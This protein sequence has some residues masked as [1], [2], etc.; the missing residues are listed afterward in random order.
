MSSSPGT[1]Q[2][3]FY[4]MNLSF[5]A[6]RFH[7]FRNLNASGSEADRWFGTSMMSDDN[8]M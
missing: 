5:D 6:P 3:S 2:E 8:H 1:A 4:E 7:D